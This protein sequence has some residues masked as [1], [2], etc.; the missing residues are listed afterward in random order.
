VS[1]IKNGGIIMNWALEGRDRIE[2]QTILEHHSGIPYRQ[3]KFEPVTSL[4]YYSC[5]VASQVSS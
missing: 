3:S 4:I 5:R 1:P 2:L